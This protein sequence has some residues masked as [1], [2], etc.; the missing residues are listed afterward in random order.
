MKVGQVLVDTKRLKI[1]S[2][3]DAIFRD[4]HNFFLD[5]GE[6]AVLETERKSSP[7][8]TGAP[9]WFQH[10]PTQDGD[11]EFEGSYRGKEGGG[12]GGGGGGCL[13][14]DGIGGSF[15]EPTVTVSSVSEL[16]GSTSL[17]SGGDGV[18]ES[19]TQRNEDY[20]VILPDEEKEKDSS[21]F[22]DSPQN[23]GVAGGESGLSAT[24]TPLHVQ[25]S[26]TTPE[27][28]FRSPSMIS[29]GGGGGGGG[30]P[31]SHSFSVIDN[32]E[33]LRAISVGGLSSAA[34]VAKEIANEGT[35]IVK[36]P[37]DAAILFEKQHDHHFDCLMIQLMQSFGVS[38]SWLGVI[39]PL[40]MESSRKVKTN[41]LA[42]DVMDINEY[43]KIKKIHGGHKSNCSLVYGVVCSKN[44]THKKMKNSLQNPTI[45]LLKCAFDFQRRENQLSSFDTL[46]L[47]E[48]KYL[49]N[50]VAR[51]KTFK[52]SIILVQK[53]VSRL[54]LEMLF[55]LGIVVAVN[56]KQ[57]VMTRIA[58]ATKGDILHS[59]DQIFFDVQLGTCG[60]FYVRDFTLP[61]GIKKTLM[62]F[63]NC[64]PKLGCVIILQGA[65]KRELKKVKNVTRFGL[66]I[67]HNSILETAFLLDEFAWPSSSAPQLLPSVDGYSSSSSTPEWPLYPSLVYPL[68]ML[69]PNELAKKLV[70]LGAAPVASKQ[71]P[72]QEGGEAKQCEDSGLHLYLDTESSTEPNLEDRLPLVEDDEFSEV[73][74][75]SV[76]P[77]LAPTPEFFIA[78]PTPEVSSE[79]EPSISQTVTPLED[80]F[81]FSAREPSDE[82]IVKRVDPK[83]LSR[84]GER[85]F[86]MALENQVVSI[87]PNVQFQAPYLQ[88]ADGREASTRQY[89][90]NVIYWSHQFG[91][92]HQRPRGKRSACDDHFSLH[93]TKTTSPL[94]MGI[95]RSSVERS[96][97]FDS[98]HSTKESDSSSSRHGNQTLTNTL[99]PF[100]HNY[101]SVSDHPLTTSIFL[102]KANSNEMKAALADYRARAGIPSEEDNF[103]FSS[104]KKASDYQLHLQNIFNKYRDFE[105]MARAFD[106]TDSLQD[107][108]DVIKP[109]E[110][111][112]VKRTGPSATRV[113]T[114][115][116]TSAR[117]SDIAAESDNSSEG[118]EVVSVNSS[119]GVVASRQ[120]RQRSPAGREEGSLEVA[121][122]N[123]RSNRSSLSPSRSHFSNSSLPD[124]GKK[125]TALE[126]RAS[127]GGGGGGGG[128][129]ESV[130]VLDFDKQVF[131]PLSSSRQV[132]SH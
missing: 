31:H 42:E 80:T 24:S 83:T 128:R 75:P 88:T 77:P 62:Y 58:R 60:H 19:S 15:V 129:E 14:P 117:I 49:K 109:S 127:G 57:S 111:D 107:E 84:L 39:T 56:V 46:Q 47:Q 37:N 54:A 68:Q 5:L 125:M 131:D 11:S 90:P 22:P 1:V 45:L 94:E 92:F 25:R 63:D 96:F 41:V 102:L 123:R 91:S 35:G 32:R 26:N 65:T 106:S 23:V 29:A 121:A 70:A 38:L 97:N 119:T 99:V 132:H 21:P 73:P 51:V 87:S 74:L 12:G 101:K 7:T 120:S 3:L 66:H 2:T 105:L 43:V 40:I 130:E 55:E 126:K 67:A 78:S 100:P 36:K 89:L 20:L 44:V 115:E 116:V 118:F 50:L 122:R 93:Y 86:S 9:K 18:S 52:P 72:D 81:S 59:L 30:G 17:P 48:E 76:T 85:E 6:A 124:G 34:E 95:T 53:S 108:Q 71:R 113:K 33:F 8:V 98:V 28:R 112:Q 16:T 69:P 104:A 110:D 79:S 27:S 103:F 13:V 114:A 61:S 64:E 4:D 10:I 82:D